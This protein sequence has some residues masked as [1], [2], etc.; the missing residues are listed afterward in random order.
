MCEESWCHKRSLTHCPSSQGW[1]SSVLLFCMCC[2]CDFDVCIS[3]G[4]DDGNFL[5]PLSASFLCWCA[6]HMC[7]HVCTVAVCV[8]FRAKINIYI[9]ISMYMY[10]LVL[11]WGHRE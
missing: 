3:L 8:P 2:V 11:S 10:S 9:I 1:T 7:F 4:R 6:V 5:S